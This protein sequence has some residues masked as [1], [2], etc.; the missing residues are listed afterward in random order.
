VE[1]MIQRSLADL[2]KYPAKLKVAVIGAG[3]MGRLLML[4][5][6]SKH[7]D[8]DVTLVNRSVDKAQAVLDDDM[9]KGRGGSNAKVAGSDKMWD[10][11][12]A[13]DVVFAATGSDVPI[14]CAKDFENATKPV[15]LMDISVP[16]N[17]AKDCETLD[18]AVSYSVDDL[19]MLQQANAAKRQGEVLKAKRLIDA[20]VSKFLLWKASQGAVPYLA[21]LQN[22][23]ENIR[24]AETEKMSLKLKG[25]H[26]KERQAVDKLTRH[27]IDQ[28]FQPIY[29]S[30]KAD[31]DVSTKKNKIAALKGIFNLE[32]VYK[33]RLL[34]TGAG[35]AGQLNA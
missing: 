25:L 10:V 15:M 6:F 24:K 1:L 19:K 29:Y 8:I 30:M 33:R 28:L 21:A 9:V 18:N 2:K 22:M 3:K 16:R 7:P 31:E 17:I 27:I 11:I 12:Y 5:L 13:S 26:E 34:P 35:T 32:P 20:E 23:A 14:I 4:A